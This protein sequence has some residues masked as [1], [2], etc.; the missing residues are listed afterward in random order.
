MTA[1]KPLQ[2]GLWRTVRQGPAGMHGK[3]Y[4]RLP[5]NRVPRFERVDIGP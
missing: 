5:G 2:A 3:W 4:G 1:I